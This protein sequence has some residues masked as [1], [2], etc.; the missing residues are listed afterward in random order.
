MMLS[1]ISSKLIIQHSCIHLM[2]NQLALMFDQLSSKQA[3]KLLCKSGR[4]VREGA[5]VQRGMRREVPHDRLRR[6]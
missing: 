5:E 1:T 6:S 3:A 2:D 4:L